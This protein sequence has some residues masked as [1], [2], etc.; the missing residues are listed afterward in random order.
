MYPQGNYVCI[1]GNNPPPPPAYNGFNPNPNMVPSNQVFVGNQG[2]APNNQ[3]FVPNQNNQGFIP[4]Q[5]NQGF[6]PNNQG[7]NPNNQGYII[8]LICPVCRRETD[9]F[10]R[11]VAGSTAYLWCFC[12]FLFT[13]ILCCWLPFC[14]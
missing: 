12:L 11:R 13:G 7:Y 2:F 5:N 9:S 4:N 6:N 8:K 14:I 1:L 3:G 10:P